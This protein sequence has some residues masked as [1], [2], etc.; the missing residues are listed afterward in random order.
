[1]GE[2]LAVGGA[3]VLATT[4]AV[5]LGGI[6]V[7]IGALRRIVG[8]QPT[9]MIDVVP[10]AATTPMGPPIILRAGD[11]FISSRIRGQMRPGRRRGF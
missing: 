4:A 5:G 8:A 7:V 1:M 6:V 11:R 2:G 10:T 9:N 3:E